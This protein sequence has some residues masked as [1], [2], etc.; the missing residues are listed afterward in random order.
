[1]FLHCIR[2]YNATPLGDDKEDPSPSVHGRLCN[3]AIQFRVLVGQPIFSNSTMLFFSALAL[4]VRHILM[5]RTIATNF[6]HIV[7]ESHSLKSLRVQYLQTLIQI[8]LFSTLENCFH[9]ILALNYLL[10]LPI[11]FHLFYI[12]SII[13]FHFDELISMLVNLNSLKNGC[14]YLTQIGLLLVV[15][16]FY[17]CIF[18]LY[19]QWYS[20]TWG[21][22]RT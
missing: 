17:S 22:Y 3:L 11:F 14:S 20:H 15:K 18:E 16:M 1:M 10:H 8:L 21:L 6:A 4:K 12:P 5:S 13:L 19:K 9:H 2:M 7:L